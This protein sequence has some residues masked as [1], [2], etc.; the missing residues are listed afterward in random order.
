MLA[1]IRSAP[2][3][4]ALP[5][6]VTVFA[7]FLGFMS[8]FYTLQGDYQSAAWFIVFA[9]ITD[10]MDGGVARVFNA[11]SQF[12]RELDSMADVINLGVAPGLLL[13]EVYYPALGFGSFILG[14]TQV[15][16]V[17]ARLA[18]YNMFGKANKRFFLGLPSPHT[19]SAIG[20]WI[21]FSDAVWGEYRYPVVMIVVVPL[22]GALMLSSFRYE[23]TEFVKPG[24]ALETWQGWLFVLS[25]VIMIIIPRYY[26]FLMVMG[27]IGIGVYRSVRGESKLSIPETAEGE[28]G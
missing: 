8:M 12:G 27:M 17:A 9:A 14:F 1:R 20:A 25:A 6:A 16:A 7:I 21:L 2:W 15:I 3:R 26:Y 22:M 5:N 19:A 11:T 4:F 23:S 28:T 18:R 24:S 10:A 13:I